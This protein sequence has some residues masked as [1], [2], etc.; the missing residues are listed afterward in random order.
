MNLQKQ[1]TK[2]KTHFFRNL[3]MKNEDNRLHSTPSNLN[4]CF[5]F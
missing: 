5:D 3:E 2:N 1:E 4:F